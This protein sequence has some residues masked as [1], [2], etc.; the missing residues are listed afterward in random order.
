MVENPGFWNWT[1]T[2]KDVNGDVLA[3]I[4]RDWRGFGFEVVFWTSSALLSCTYFLQFNLISEVLSLLSILG[5]S[6]FLILLSYN[7]TR[8][9]WHGLPIMH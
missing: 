4:D 5:H 1:F 6:G 2:L 7:F 3:Q 9:K 8:K